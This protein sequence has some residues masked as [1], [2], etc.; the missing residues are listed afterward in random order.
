[1]LGHATIGWFEDVQDP[2]AE[3]IISVRMA[4][5]SVI[6][7]ARDAAA[8]LPETLTSV[9]AQTYGDWDLVLIDDASTDGTGELVGVL[10]HRALVLRNQRPLGPAAARNLGVARA[11]G[12]LI[13][14]LDADDLWKPSYLERQ[15]AA[16]DDA[17][18][19]GR[20][21]AV[22]A[23]DAELLGP[24]GNTGERW[25]DR[26]RI[27]PAVTINALLREN[28]VYNSVVMSRDVFVASG[29]YQPELVGVED[30][31]LWLR[32][33][34]A[35][36]AIVVNDE[37]LATY[38][39]RP[40]ALSANAAR[41][42]AGTRTVYEA[43]LARGRLT[44]RQRTLARRQ[45]RLYQLLERR[46]EL[47]AYAAAGSPR[48]L[49]TLGLLPATARVALEH[50]ERWAMWLRRGP[51]RAGAGRHADVQTG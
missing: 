8:T 30:F 18:R 27:R 15:V 29:G 34:E 3:P 11:S 13:A 36:W 21:V 2:Q 9:A 50:P 48:G 42:A 12:E 14:T 35:G 44:R 17:H 33:V 4:R 23:C 20:P 46:A 40:D 6:V 47:S 41:I 32:L 22:V 24:D 31:D 10:G 37:P 7:A 5:V 28:F 19:A 51:R 26:V 16:Y 1:M 38:R 45:R 43:A 49:A 25:S 39:L